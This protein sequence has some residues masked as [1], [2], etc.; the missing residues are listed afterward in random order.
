MF[1]SLAAT[2]AHLQGFVYRSF[3]FSGPVV[4]IEHEHRDKILYPFGVSLALLK[5]LE[6]ALEARRPLRAPLPN[7]PG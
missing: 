6:E 1:Y 7:G 3:H 5:S 2:D 4:A